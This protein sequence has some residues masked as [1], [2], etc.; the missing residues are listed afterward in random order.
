[1]INAGERE[2]ECEK[3]RKTRIMGHGRIAIE[4]GCG[5]G[6]LRERREKK[7]RKRSSANKKKSKKRNGERRKDEGSEETKME[8]WRD[9]GNKREGKTGEV[10]KKTE[11][12]NKENGK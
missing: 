4:A 2:R 11:M 9:G 7:N 3:V 5:G 8:V 1:M 6:G 12:R 10:L